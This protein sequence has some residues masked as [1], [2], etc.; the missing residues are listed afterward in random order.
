MA[1]ASVGL[2]LL[3]LL[4][5]T[6]GL[7]QGLAFRPIA[8]VVGG[9]VI[10]VGMVVARSC[11]SG[12]FHKLGSGMLGA[13]VGLVALVGLAGWAA[14][15]LLARQLTVPGPTVLPGGEAATLPGVLGLP[16]PLVAALL[17]TTVSVALWRRP[18]RE[19]PRY[20]WQWGWRRIGVGLGVVITTGWA[21]AGLGG[22]SFGPSSVGA[23]ASVAG[24]SPNYWLI[25][26]LVGIVAGGTLSAR[27]AGGFWLRGEEPVRYLQLVA[28]GLL[29]GAGGWI[30]GGCN[31]GHGL[32]GV[33]QLNVSSFVVVAAMVG[34]VWLARLAPHR[35][36][37]WSSET[38]PTR[39]SRLRSG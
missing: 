23:V 25:T 31:L 32:S 4:P 16:R 11:V 27:T 18:G 15:E 29:L 34:G 2:A 7:N 1:L 26:F 17:L 38:E 10:G 24:G 36:R 8:N 28:G 14:G 33:A 22:S 12:L 3:F 35:F 39:P 13:L 37:R 20:D 19:S 21:M 30:A 9:L 6:D 5:G